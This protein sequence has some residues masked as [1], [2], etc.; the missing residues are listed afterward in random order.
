MSLDQKDKKVSNLKRIQIKE[1]KIESL[2]MRQQLIAVIILC[3]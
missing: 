2:Q 1:N 3:C